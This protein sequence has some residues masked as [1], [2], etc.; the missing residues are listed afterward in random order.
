M[1][2]LRDLIMTT[3]GGPT[4]A[5]RNGASTTST[6]SGNASTATSTYT[7]TAAAGAAVITPVIFFESVADLTKEVGTYTHTYIYVY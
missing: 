6:S 7:A 1:A 5:Y 2:L 4:N 3:E